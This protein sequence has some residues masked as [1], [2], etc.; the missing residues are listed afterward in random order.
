MTFVVLFVEL[1]RVVPFSVVRSF[2]VLS[3]MLLLLLLLTRQTCSITICSESRL[4]P[5]RIGPEV[6]RVYLNFG[7][8][9]AETFGRG[10]RGT[11]ALA[12]LVP[13][14]LTFDVCTLKRPNLSWLE[15]RRLFTG[16]NADVGDVKMASELWWR[17]ILRNVCIDSFD[18]E[19]VGVSSV[20]SRLGRVGTE[21]EMTFLV[22][23]GKAGGT[24][25]PASSLM[26]LDKFVSCGKL[27]FFLSVDA[28]FSFRVLS[29]S[30]D[31]SL[32][33][34]VV[35]DLSFDVLSLSA[36]SALASLS[37]L[38]SLSSSISDSPFE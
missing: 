27:V 2:N 14:D 6:E 21:E 35:G 33:V 5:V 9:V 20:E 11:G 28:S 26:P 3:F 19:A 34:V 16:G 8:S 30:N 31:L 7:F 18:V 4:D 13:L 17:S 37:P 15:W 22:L 10:G 32:A 29:F 1:C 25:L 38:A 36:W 23:I 12:W 24:L